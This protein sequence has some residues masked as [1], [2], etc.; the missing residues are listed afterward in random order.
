ASQGKIAEGLDHIRHAVEIR[1]SPENLSSLAQSLAYP[2]KDKEG[3]AEQKEQAYTLMIEADSLAD[4]RNDSSYAALLAQLAL[5]TGHD[6]VFTRTTAKLVSTHP[7]LM[8][9][10]YFNA[11]VAAEDEQ[12]SKAEGEIRKAES[13]GLPSEAAERI[14]ASGIHT[15]V[16]VWRYFGY[17]LC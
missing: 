6:D 3:T 9:T 15:R 14:L 2:A 12:W 11:I 7:E 5:E 17:A 16:L 1:R 8:V 13:L 10:H 4:V